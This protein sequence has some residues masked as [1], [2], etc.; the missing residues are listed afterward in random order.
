MNKFFFYSQNVVVNGIWWFAHLLALGGLVTLCYELAVVT[1]KLERIQIHGDFRYVAEVAPSI[2]ACV[3][4]LLVSISIYFEKIEKAEPTRS[5]KTFT[6]PF[7]I[8]LSIALI[9]LSFF[10]GG[11]SS[12]A[13]DALGAIAL[14][15]A[16]LRLTG[17]PDWI[18]SRHGQ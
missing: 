18:S 1:F 6:A 8:L 15:G 16:M 7:M 17:L 13:I 9:F 3:S 2:L 11:L 4:L 12:L 10:S 14:G 5:S